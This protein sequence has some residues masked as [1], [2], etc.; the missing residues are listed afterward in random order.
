M[1]Q[2]R[3][4]TFTDRGIYCPR[5][6]VYIDPWKP[7]P[8]ALITHGHA[9]HARSGHGQ[10]LCTASA[11]PIMRHR[12][13]SIDLQTVE[14]GA[15]IDMNGVQISFH[16]A[17]HVIGSAQIRLAYK[18]EIWVI[19]GDYKIEPDGI[20][21]P[22][23][24]VQCTHFVSECTF[25]LP[26][27]TWESQATVAAQI[28][29][30][31]RNNSAAGITSIIGAYSLGKAQRIL[32][33]LDTDIAA[34]LTH[35]AIEASNHVL[36]AQ[37][38]Q[39]PKTHLVTPDFDNKAHK[40]ALV[41]APPAA[42]GSKWVKKFGPH[43]TGFASGWMRLRGVRRRRALDQGFVMSDHSDWNGLLS[44]IN[45]TNAENIFV[46]HGYTDIFAR[47][48]NSIGYNAAIVETAFEGEAAQID[49]TDES[50]A[51]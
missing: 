34:I 22:F 35:G 2:E 51:S 23:E 29:K 15:S 25:G 16:P 39:L 48:L 8:R 19:S 38:V 33:L 44:A 50:V 11:A 12:L 21:E 45:A 47:H 17:G 26:I 27:F 28:K 31:W 6:D 1:A 30:W 41:L 10:Y 43:S 14:Y 9:D 49:E 13:D 5:A 4:I 32:S 3:L 36:R 24:P 42:L 20:S 37:G 7:V 40:G 18:G 46:T